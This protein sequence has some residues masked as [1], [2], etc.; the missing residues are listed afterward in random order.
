M[1]SRFCFLRIRAAHEWEKRS[2]PPREEWLIVEWPEGVS[3]SV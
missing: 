1:R 2:T 3:S